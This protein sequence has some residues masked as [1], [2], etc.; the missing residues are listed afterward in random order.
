MRPHPL[1]TALL[2]AIAASAAAP[3]L[4]QKVAPGLWEYQMTIKSGGARMDSAMAQM[5]QQLAAMPPDQRKMMEDMMARQGMGMAAGKPTSVRVCITP[6]QAARD[7]MPQHDG[8]CKQTSKERSGRVM[9]FKFACTGEP[10]SSGEGEYT[11]ISD[12]EHKGHMTVNT[13][14]KGQPERMEMEQAG[15]WISADCGAI[16]PRP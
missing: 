9:R 5:Q 1:V 2:F 7:E 16:K 12:K 6:E 4:A 10:A 13:T 3:A 8:R 15:K 14:V 11:L